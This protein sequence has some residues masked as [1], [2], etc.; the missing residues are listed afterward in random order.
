LVIGFFV[1]R[2]TIL[3]KTEIRYVLG[4]PVSG[5]VNTDSLKPVKETIPAT[6]ILPIIPDTVYINDTLYITQKVDTA[7]I[8]ADYIILREY[9]PVLF[10]SSTQGKLS[11]LATVQY[12]KLQDLKYEY[13]PVI[14]E[15]TKYRVKL[16]QP[17]AGISY[18]TLNLAIFSAGTFYYDIGIDFNYIR[19]LDEKTSGYGIGLK[20]KF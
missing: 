13:T 10:D 4:D 18:N 17:Y 14:R 11:L 16:M 12:N 1:G 5:S 6:P 19:N 3:H 8:I 15:V 20:Y 9:T 2:K 7:S